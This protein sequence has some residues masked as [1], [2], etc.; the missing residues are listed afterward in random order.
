M[1]DITI[2]MPPFFMLNNLFRG[3]EYSYNV[4]KVKLIVD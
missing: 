3:N 1:S 4:V 2:Q